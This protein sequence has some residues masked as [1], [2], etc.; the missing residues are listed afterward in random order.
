VV[1]G[2]GTHV[3]LPWEARFAKNNVPVTEVAEEFSFPVICKDGTLT[4]QA[5]FR[6]R[7]DFRRPIEYISGVGSVGS[8][9]KALV[10]TAIVKHLQKLDIQ[11]ALEGKDVLNEELRIEFVEGD[12]DFE[13]RFGVQV[14]DVTV[15]NLLPSDEVQRTRSALNEAEIVARGTALL[16]GFKTVAAMNKAL[17]A[18]SITRQQ[19]D[20]ARREFR[21]IS[22]NMEGA[23]I[24]RYEVAVSGLSPEVATAISNLL[25]NPNAARVVSDLVGRTGKG[26]KK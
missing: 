15:S 6:L 17:D 26:S 20:E 16:L 22:G 12:S 8:D 13:K 10:Q 14:G 21:I 2:P 3:S 18:G 11:Q 23:N 19:A 1:Y 9:M 4:V 24:N 25:N 5:S 7:P